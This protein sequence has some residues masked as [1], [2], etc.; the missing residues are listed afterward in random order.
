[1]DR[2]ATDSAEQPYILGCK[3]A[4][5]VKGQPIFGVTRRPHLQEHVPPKRSS[6]FKRNIP[7][8]S[9]KYLKF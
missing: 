6:I 5:P 3:A 1:M 9:G 2:G 8:R 7:N 4:Y